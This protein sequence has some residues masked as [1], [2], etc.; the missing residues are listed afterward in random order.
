MPNSGAFRSLHCLIYKVLVPSAFR[1]NICYSITL[2]RTCQ[3]LFSTSFEIF[4][5]T[6]L[7]LSSSSNSSVII[8][9]SFRFVKPFFRSLS[10]S[11]SLPS[12]RAP[13]P[14]NSLAIIANSPRFVKPFLQL[15]QIFSSLSA[16][17]LPYRLTAWLV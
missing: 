12:R 15:S 14:L 6:Q 3:A 2:F 8:P 16:A 17:V 1:R 10:K 5:C 11:F 7:A 13:A 9:G 4:F